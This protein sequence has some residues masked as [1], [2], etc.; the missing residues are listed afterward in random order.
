MQEG[1]G[2]ESDSREGGW[3]KGQVY[4]A[5][6]KMKGRKGARVDVTKRK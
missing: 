4:A 5:G 2:G 6:G 1:D 3:D